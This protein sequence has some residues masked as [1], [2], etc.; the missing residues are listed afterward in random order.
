MASRTTFVSVKPKS[1]RAP[2]GVP[3]LEVRVPLLDHRVVEF[4]F[5]LPPHFKRRNGTS[6]W[7]LRQVLNRYVP[8]SLLNRPKMG[9]TVPIDTWL[10]GPLREWAQAHPMRG[11]TFRRASILA[12]DWKALGL[13]DTS[14]SAT[15]G[16]VDRTMI[17]IS[18][19]LSYLHET[20]AAEVAWVCL[21]LVAMLPCKV[22]E[23]R[24]V[25]LDP[26]DHGNS[27]GGTPSF[28][29]SFVQ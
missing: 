26:P 13:S 2:L 7:L 22:P 11:P 27:H 4:A 25:S 20:L 8:K 14:L 3:P 29:S 18:Y 1:N 10:R 21:E 28:S 6:K 5:R 12:S 24:L 9:F 23:L 17:N 16:S 19:R 15:L